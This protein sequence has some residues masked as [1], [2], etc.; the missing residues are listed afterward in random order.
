M[1]RMCSTSKLFTVHELHRLQLL[2][3]TR[4]PTTG[5]CTVHPVALPSCHDL[6]NL[7]INF[8][9]LAGIERRLPFH[10]L[11]SALDQQVHK[12]DLAL[13]IRSRFEI[14]QVPPVLAES[15]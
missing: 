4:Q 5:I 3:S 10:E 6:G 8:I 14:S 7:G 15:T 9:G 11:C 13:P 2:N 12:L 1:R